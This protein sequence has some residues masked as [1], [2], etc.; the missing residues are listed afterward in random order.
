MNI[1]RSVIRS[2][3]YLLARPA[4]LAPVALLAF[5]CGT[6]APEGDNGT[7]AAPSNESLVSGSSASVQAA[8]TA[9]SE[10]QRV[11]AY[12][13]SLYGAADVRHTFTT[14]FG[15]VVDCIDF[16]KHPAVRAAAKAGTPVLD[17][18]PP[19]APPTLPSPPAIDDSVAFNGQLDEK[20]APRACPAGTV[21][22]LRETVENIGAAGGLDHYLWAKTHSKPSRSPVPT[23]PAGP[24]CTSNPTKNGYAWAVAND[25]TSNLGGTTIAAVYNP[26]STVNTNCGGFQ[27]PSC[28]HSLAQVWATTGTCEYPSNCTT[29]A[30]GNAVQS[31]ELGWHV[32][33]GVEHDM[34]THLFSFSTQN[35]YNL[36]TSGGGCYNTC[37]FIPVSSPSYVPGQAIAGVVGPFQGKAPLEY[38][39]Q[40]FN[41]GPTAPAQYQ[42][43]YVYVNG[44]LIGYYPGNIFFGNMTTHATDFE[45]GGE[46]FSDYVNAPNND[47]VQMGS[48]VS[49][50][51]NGFTNVAYHRSIY[52]LNA[53]S[54]SG[55]ICGT[56]LCGSGVCYTAMPLSGNTGICGYQA[57][58]FYALSTTD[59]PGGTQSTCWA[60][61]FYY[62]GGI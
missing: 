55:T 9:A 59:A 60:S 12:L 1:P 37:S 50:L 31:V 43:W 51:G 56:P 49:S 44:A 22:Y 47:D 19:F 13:D 24:V 18:A 16:Q 3:R 2:R 52:T 62:G 11:R 23:S 38:A 46:V 54:G 26:G 33:P 42:N 8:A 35:G 7:G 39:F 28:E 14:K 61:Y 15:E 5:G 4:W 20:G 32:D 30:S 45:V 21:P 53:G 36:N 6:A 27:Q 34:K 48:G 29:G 41:P 10:P 58:S 17:E 40:V 25:S 57:S